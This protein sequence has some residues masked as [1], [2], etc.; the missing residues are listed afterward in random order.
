[1]YPPFPQEGKRLR[2]LSAGAELMKE[3]RET[4]CARGAINTFSRGKGLL[5]TVGLCQNWFLKNRRRFAPQEKMPTRS[6]FQPFA[7]I[8]LIRP[9]AW[10]AFF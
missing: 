10:N 1:M 8:G 6:V 7:R 5:R 3:N 4:N 2:G 9:S